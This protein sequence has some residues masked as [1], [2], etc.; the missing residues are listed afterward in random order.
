[1]AH[2][3]PPA[4]AAWGDAHDAYKKLAETVGLADTPLVV[5]GV[6]I[7]NSETY[8]VNPK[9]AVRDSVF[10]NLTQHQCDP[11][12]WQQLLRIRRAPVHQ[13]RTIAAAGCAAQFSP[14]VRLVLNTAAA[15]RVVYCDYSVQARFGLLGLKDDSFPRI[16]LFKKGADTAKPVDYSGAMKDSSELLR[17]TV[18]QT[19]VFVGVKVGGAV[20]LLDGG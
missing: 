4:A 16:K 1:M 20:A 7:S 3:A 17:W 5:A 2:A 8:P 15:A 19:G 18:E 13:T 12:T 6:P 11:S 9:L 14:R 10:T